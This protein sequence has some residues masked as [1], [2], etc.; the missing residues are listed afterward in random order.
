[1]YGE[2]IA[3]VTRVVTFL[4]FSFSNYY[5]KLVVRIYLIEGGKVLDL[6]YLNECNDLSMLPI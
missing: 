3:F 6:F 2:H 1:M 4:T 5:F